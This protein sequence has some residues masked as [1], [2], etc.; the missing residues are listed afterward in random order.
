MAALA[1]ELPLVLGA[2]DATRYRQ[3]FVLQEAGDM[4][5]AD[6]LIGQITDPVLMG[7]VQSQR[8]MHPTA[9]RSTFVELRDWLATYADHPEADRIHAL[10]LRRKPA[11]AGR[12]EAPRPLS[13]GDYTAADGEYVAPSEVYQSPRG[14]NAAVGRQVRSIARTINARVADGWPTG[15]LAILDGNEAQRLLDPV[16]QAMARALIAKGY[17]LASVDDKAFTQGK[18]AGNAS[19]Q[20][21]AI[22]HWIAGLAAWRMGRIDDAALE[23]ETFAG[24]DGAD[25]W[26][27]SA[28]AFWAARAHLQ[29]G[30]P[31][32]VRSWLVVAADYPLTFYGQLARRNLGMET[33]LDWSPVPLTA[34][35]RDLLL[36]IPATR[37]VLALLQAGQDDLAEEELTRLARAA[38]A[39]L[40]RPLLAIATRA[41]MPALSLKLADLIEATYGEQI[42][43]GLYPLVAWQPQDGYRVDRALILAFARQESGFNTDARSPAGALGLMQLMPA[44][45]RYIGRDRSLR[46][47]GL[48][49]LSEP[50]LNLELGQR[51]IQYLQANDAVGDNL[52][53]LTAAYNGGPGNLRRWVQ[54][55]DF[56]NDPL[57]FIESIPSR[58]TR[59]FI[60]RVLAN[61]WIYRQRMGQSNPSLDAIAAGVWPAYTGLD[62]QEIATAP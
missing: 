42:P 57:L 50:D 59:I 32:R 20:Y 51:Y 27:I 2:E 23:F 5:A 56:R 1:A 46:G 60:E 49:R 4:A 21:A 36:D 53:M 13:A 34:A 39:D 9:H 52:F 16:E 12:P 47:D 28:A 22:G 37:R 14:R 7:Y 17:F 43:A 35:T 61:L 26:T 30:R 15:A 10:A 24:A 58:E 62:G 11:N 55:A 44:T 54:A 33:P 45:A 48:D 29:A 3:V 31:E 41:H 38:R 19:P 6:R 8:Y 18:A 25:P 40:W